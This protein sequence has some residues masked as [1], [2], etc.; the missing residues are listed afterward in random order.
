MYGVGSRFQ[1]QRAGF[2]P[3]HWQLQFNNYLLL[4]V[5]RKEENKE[6]EAGMTHLKTSVVII[7]NASKGILCNHCIYLIHML[8]NMYYNL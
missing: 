5:S 4:T 6:K 3:R 2:E 1:Y 8:M 7:Y